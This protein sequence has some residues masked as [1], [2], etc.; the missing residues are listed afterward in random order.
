[1]GDFHQVRAALNKPWQAGFGGAAYSHMTSG[2]WLHCGQSSLQH[3]EDQADIPIDV[4]IDNC[5]GCSRFQE[6][7]VPEWSGRLQGERCLEE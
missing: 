3:G 5:S 2:T 6:S 4:T 7:F 1:M